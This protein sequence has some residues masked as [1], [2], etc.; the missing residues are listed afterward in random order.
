MTSQNIVQSTI[1]EEVIS[2]TVH[3]KCH[4]TLDGFS[5]GK[6]LIISSRTKLTSFLYIKVTFWV[7]FGNDARQIS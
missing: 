3:S 7:F 6:F 5:E 1:L 4:G 2:S